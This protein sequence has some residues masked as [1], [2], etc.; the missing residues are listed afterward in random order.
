LLASELSHDFGRT[1]LR[2]FD[3]RRVNRCLLELIAHLHRRMIIVGADL[4]RLLQQSLGLCIQE[5]DELLPTL[6]D[7]GAEG[8]QQDVSGGSR[9]GMFGAENRS[10]SGADRRNQAAEMRDFDEP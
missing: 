8:R 4:S 1:W 3:H 10:V 9:K 5:L 7:H 6:I 2:R